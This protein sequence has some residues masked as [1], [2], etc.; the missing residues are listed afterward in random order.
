M[1]WETCKKPNLFNKQSLLKK[2]GTTK[3]TFL[4][5]QS[6]SSVPINRG[7]HKTDIT[8]TVHC[9]KK[10][11]SHTKLPGICMLT[12]TLKWVFLLMIWLY[13]VLFLILTNKLQSPFINCKLS[14]MYILFTIE[15]WH[16]LTL[17]DTCSF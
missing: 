3:D 17:F 8:L 9:S 1:L 4:C 7:I 13:K 15:V 5:L 10:T 14:T 2:R 11:N 16:V 6:I 12:L